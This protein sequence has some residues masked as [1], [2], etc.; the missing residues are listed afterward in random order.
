MSLCYDTSRNCIADGLTNNANCGLLGPCK[1]C[2]QSEQC[3]AGFCAPKCNVV[4]CP[5]GC[6]DSSGNCHP[7]AVSNDTVCGIGGLTCQSCTA[8]KHCTYGLCQSCSIFT[9]RLDAAMQTTIAS[10]VKRMLTIAEILAPN[11]NNAHLP[12]GQFLLRFAWVECVD[13]ATGRHCPVCKAAART[14]EVS[15]VSLETR[16]TPAVPEAAHVAYV[17][18]MSSAST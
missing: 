17:V 5:T 13:V 4:T 2:T 10:L 18:R 3:V 11:V 14:M 8:P 12:L 7:D 6:C 15:I 9:V 1:Q 16:Q